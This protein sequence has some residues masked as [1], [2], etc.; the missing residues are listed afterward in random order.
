VGKRP[1]RQA[2]ELVSASLT[3][4]MR[5]DKEQIDEVQWK[6]ILGLGVS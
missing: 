1:H 6:Q 4:E 2:L 3:F 5:Y